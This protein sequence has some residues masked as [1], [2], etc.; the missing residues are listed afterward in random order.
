MKQAAI[1]FGYY[2]VITRVTTTGTVNEPDNGEERDPTNLTLGE[3]NNLLTAWNDI[4]PESI[5]KNAT[6]TWGTK[7]W[8]VTSDKDMVPLSAARGGTSSKRPHQQ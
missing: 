4:T 3:F 1:E 6:I 5:Q 8:T 2:N 7:T